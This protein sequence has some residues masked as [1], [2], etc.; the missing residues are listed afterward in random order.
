[1]SEKTLMVG[2]SPRLHGSPNILARA[3]AD[4]ARQVDHEVEL[5]PLNAHPKVILDRTNCPYA[6]ECRFRDA[7][8]AHNCEATASEAPEHAIGNLRG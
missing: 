3:F 5:V 4:E 1:M 8:S 7:W 2:T 6:V